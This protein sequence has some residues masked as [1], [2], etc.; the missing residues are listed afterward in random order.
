MRWSIHTSFHLKVLYFEETHLAALP[1]CFSLE[2]F[3]FSE[4]FLQL[5]L[6]NVTPHFWIPYLRRF[7]NLISSVDGEVP[8]LAV[9]L[10][11]V[12][13][14]HG[15]V[16]GDELVASRSLH[17]VDL[18]LKVVWLV[19][20]VHLDNAEHDDEHCCADVEVLPLV[21]EVDTY[22][23]SSRAKTDCEMWYMSVGWNYCSICYRNIEG[24]AKDDCRR[25]QPGDQCCKRWPISANWASLS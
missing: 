2:W 25:K 23:E 14:V 6:T 12:P 20:F 13:D 19:W 21:A 10:V 18:R 5:H 8:E 1:P 24:H 4:L 11:E 22:S 17:H 3:W 15:V 16:V 9:L 7:H